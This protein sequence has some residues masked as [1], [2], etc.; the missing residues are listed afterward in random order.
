M[1]IKTFGLFNEKVKKFVIVQDD[2]IIITFS[3]NGGKNNAS[4][5]SSS[6]LR[7][8]SLYMSCDEARQLAEKLINKTL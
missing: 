8:V 7:A 6:A 1:N 2:K 4:S 3:Y 5:Q